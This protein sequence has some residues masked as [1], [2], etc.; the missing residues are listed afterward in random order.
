EQFMHATGEIVIRGERHE[1]DCFAIRDRSWRQIRTEDPGGARRTP[2]IG[3]T[4]IS[5]GEEFSLSVAS[6]E[7][8]D[9]DPRWLGLFDVPDDAPTHHAGWISRGGETLAIARVRRNVLEHHPRLHAAVRQELEI[10][11]ETGFVH[12]FSGEAISMAPMYSW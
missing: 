5:Y 6:I 8:K 3:W 11:D 1:V 9:T 10:E 2:P 12:R 7:A 4:P